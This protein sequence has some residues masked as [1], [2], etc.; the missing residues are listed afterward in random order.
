MPFRK[1]KNKLVEGR[2]KQL[3]SIRW[4]N[5]FALALVIVG[6]LI[7]RSFGSNMRSAVATIKNIAPGHTPEDQV[8]GLVTLALLGSNNRDSK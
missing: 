3:M 8:V 1:R 7:M 2:M 4:N 6:L 5:V